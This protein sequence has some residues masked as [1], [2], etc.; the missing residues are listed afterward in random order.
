M[1]LSDGDHGSG[2]SLSAMIFGNFSDLVVGQW[3]SLD[4][5]FDPYTGSSTGYTAREGGNTN[6]KSGTT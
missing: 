4:V 2:S 3:S 5:L 1:R 6:L